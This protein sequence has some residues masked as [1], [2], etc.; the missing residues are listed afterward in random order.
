MKKIIVMGSPLFLNRG[1]LKLTTKQAA[2]RMHCLK[3]YIDDNGQKLDGTYEIIAETC[4]KI[5]EE[6]WYAGD[7]S[8]LRPDIAAEVNKGE[9]LAEKDAVI[10]DLTKKLDELVPYV[11]QLEKDQKAKDALIAELNVKLEAAGKKK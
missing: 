11:E 6:F 7:T 3:P 1:I 5:G 2:A 9:Q 10:D 4:F 8:N